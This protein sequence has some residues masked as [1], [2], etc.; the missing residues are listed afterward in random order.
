MGGSHSSPTPG[1]RD[2]SLFDGFS[3]EAVITIAGRQS[4][5]RSHPR[6]PCAVGP[7]IWPFFLQNDW[8][9]GWAPLLWRRFSSVPQQ[10][11]RNTGAKT[12]HLAWRSLSQSLQIAWFCGRRRK[13]EKNLAGR[14]GSPARFTGEGCQPV[15]GTGKTRLK[16][17]A[18]EAYR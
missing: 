1:E 8:V 12:S 14:G 4:F 11:R 15:R 13:T 10:P 2:R 17:S 18:K 9:P 5:L 3:N 6:N 16:P 7:M